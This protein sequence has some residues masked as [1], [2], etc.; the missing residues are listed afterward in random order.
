ME[1][2][3]QHHRRGASDETI[4]ERRK[5]D[6]DRSIPD[7]DLRIGAA[8]SAVISTSSPVRAGFGELV[9]VQIGVSETTCVN[10]STPR[11]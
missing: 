4:A 2:R 3:H 1:P 8:H 5:T 10:L 9:T 11:A 6:R 7:R